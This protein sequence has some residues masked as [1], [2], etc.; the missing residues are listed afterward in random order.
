MHFLLLILKNVR[1]HPLRS[2]LTGLGTVVLVLVVTIVWAFL[3]FLDVSMQQQDTDFKAIVTE[4]WR[5]PS[6]M[7]WAYAESL[8]RGAVRTPQDERPLDSM[9]W[10]FYGGTLDRGPPTRENIVFFVAMD[11][12]KITVMMEELDQLRSTNKS[13]AEELDKAVAKLLKTRNGVILG[14]DRMNAVKKNIGQRFTIYSMMYRGI[15]LEF[16]IVGTFPPGRYDNSAVMNSEYLNEAI[17][18][19]NRKPG[20]PRHPLTEKSLNLVW[21]R[22]RDRDAFNRVAQQIE[23]SPLYT[24][25]AVKVE[26]AASLVAAALEPFRDILW[27]LR[28]LLV[29]AALATLSLIIANAISI[30]VRERRMELAVLKVL[31]FRPYQILL[32]VLGEAILLGT[33]AGTLSSWLT[34]FVVNDVVGG[35]KFPVGFFTSFYI[36]ADALWWGP[37]IGALTALWGSMAPAWSARNVKV[38]EVFSKVA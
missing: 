10:Q 38:A 37:A 26:T 12:R 24:S 11:A 13:Q 16:E 35:V 3:S 21:L 36:P 1:R 9:T 14:L 23:S 34:Y 22:V 32:L 5:I 6:Q 29:P 18:A 20:N 2:T 15:D 8:G 28:W 27:G 4:R 30:S 25:P 19:Y 33:V 7:P 17:E 31:G